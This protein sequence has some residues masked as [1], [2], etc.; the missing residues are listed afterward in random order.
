MSM[1][2]QRIAQAWLEAPD[3]GIIELTRDWTDAALPPLSLGPGGPAFAR[4]TRV[5]DHT[6][7]CEGGFFVNAFHEIFFFLQIAIIRT[8]IR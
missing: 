6:F 7:G 8:S 5:A 3:S 4:L 2:E 1:H